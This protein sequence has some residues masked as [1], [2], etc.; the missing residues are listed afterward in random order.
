[1]GVNDYGGILVMPRVGWIDAW[2]TDP[3][4]SAPFRHSEEHASP[5]RYAVTLDDDG[6]VDSTL[7]NPVHVY[8]EVGDFTATLVVTDRDG[9]TGSDEI[10]VFVE[11]AE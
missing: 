3:G 7:Q 1:M 8:S 10:D 6:T 2:T 9:N 5:G 11:R 4:R